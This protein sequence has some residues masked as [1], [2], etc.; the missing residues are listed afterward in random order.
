MQTDV[1]TDDEVQ[2]FLD[3]NGGLAIIE[4]YAKYYFLIM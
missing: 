1:E 3:Q 4:V 2:A